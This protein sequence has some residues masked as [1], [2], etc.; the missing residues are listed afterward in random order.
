L[1]DEAMKWITI[2]RGAAL[3]IIEERDLIAA[4]VYMEMVMWHERGDTEYRRPILRN[5][6][7][8]DDWHE[9]DD[10]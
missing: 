7:I 3:R 4:P 2:S 9:A 6:L 5:N 10:G 1:G 8:T